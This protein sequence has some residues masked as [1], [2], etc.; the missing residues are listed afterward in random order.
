MR[1]YEIRPDEK[2]WSRYEIDGSHKWGLPGVQCLTCGNTWTSVGLSYPSTDLSSL[3]TSERYFK[4]GAVSVEAMEELRRPL[5]A[6]MPPD[7][8]LKPGS[9][10]GPLSGKAYGQIG[11]VAFCGSWTL[12]MR[13]EALRTLQRAGVQGLVGVPANLKWT[14]GTVPIELLELNIEPHGL[15]APSLL[16]PEG[17]PTC[18]VCGYRKLKAPT[19]MVLTHSSLPKG[20]DIFRGRDFTTHIFATDRF[21]EAV[22]KFKLTG[23]LCEEVGITESE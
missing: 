1:T 19:Q 17:V 23:I 6:I 13:K 11:D 3:P 22:Q 14:R 15:L 5:R 9:T 4:K 20:I 10:F 8:L 16:P 21:V 2:Q 18:S 7:A 12:L